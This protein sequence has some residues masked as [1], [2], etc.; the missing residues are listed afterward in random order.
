M[1][2]KCPLSRA[3]CPYYVLASLQ[4]IKLHK[5]VENTASSSLIWQT[6]KDQSEPMASECEL[7]TVG[8]GLRIEQAIQGRPCSCSVLVPLENFSRTAARTTSIVRVSEP[9]AL[10]ANKL[11]AAN[12]IATRAYHDAL[13]RFLRSSINM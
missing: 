10:E 8:L 12:R 1:S 7:S 3:L 6:A 2:A 13:D 4:K 11:I 9:V 5:G